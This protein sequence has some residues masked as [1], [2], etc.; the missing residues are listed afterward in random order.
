VVTRKKIT[1]K[2]AVKSSHP[3]I[4]SSE[5]KPPI[6]NAPATSIAVFPG[7]FDPLTIGHVDI[8]ER[9]LTIFDKVVVGVLINHSKHSLFSPGERVALIKEQF[10]AHG[11]RIQVE[12]FSGLL[13]KLVNRVKSRVIIRGLRAI[14]DFDYEAQMALVNRRLAPQVETFFMTAR[15]ENSYI[16]SS[17]VKQVALLGGD[18]SGMVPIGVA[19]ELLKKYQDRR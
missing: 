7:S 5:I 13:V 18:V 8:I 2:R 10:L 16:S 6:F 12:S 9:A 14:S 4:D 19:R 3:G 17:I 1:K 11:D 15:E